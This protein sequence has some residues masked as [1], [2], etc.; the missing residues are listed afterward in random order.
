MLLKKKKEKE[1]HLQY[2]YVSKKKKKKPAYKWTGQFELKLFKSRLSSKAEQRERV[3]D[4]WIGRQ[5]MRRG[6]EELW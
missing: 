2:L 5:A 3:L 6:G 4:F 1:I